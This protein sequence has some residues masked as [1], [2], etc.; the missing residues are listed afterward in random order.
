MRWTSVFVAILLGLV[1]GSMGR[2]QA[3]ANVKAELDVI[4]KAQEEA[5]SRYHEGLAAGKTAEAKQAAVDRY[6]EQVHKHTEEALALVQAHPTDPVVVEAL[7][8]VIK[9]A[10]A[11]PG[12][13][14]YRAI[15]ILLKDHVRDPG[16]G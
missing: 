9:T 3:P 4:V 1:N 16:M 10:R 11:G 7:K 5:S 13:E 8:F 6:L 14:S 2:A 12:D 15:A